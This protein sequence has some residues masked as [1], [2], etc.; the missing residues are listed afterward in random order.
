MAEPDSGAPGAKPKGAADKKP[1]PKPETAPKAPSGGNG[2]ASPLRGRRGWLLLVAVVIGA[3]L[4]AFAAARHLEDAGKIG[5]AIV[6]ATKSTGTA[7]IGGP[8][9]LTDH[10]GNRVTEKTYAGKF[11]LV[12]FGYTY[13]PDVCPT[14]LTEIS[15]ALD[16]LGPAADKI[17]PI[18]IS[19]DPA[20]DTPEQLHEYATYF[21]PRLVGL[22]G[23]PEQ[24]AAVARA[25]RVYYAK[26]NPKDKDAD[27]EDYSMDHSALVYLMGPD[28]NFR[29]HFSHGMDA[30]TMA[31]RMRE[32]VAP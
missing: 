11:M 16:L 13:C 26:V 23:T 29:Q 3:G 24:V 4:L 9:Q 28:G 31:N 7:A 25:Y 12:Y 5:E 20:R 10:N 1:E 18:F 2:G 27:P 22:T 21:H 17:V 14:G 32:I 30:E 15:N 8:F 6:K 19:V